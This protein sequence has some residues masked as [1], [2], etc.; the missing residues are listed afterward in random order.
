[1]YKIRLLGSKEQ[2]DWNPTFCYLESLFYP[3]LYLVNRGRLIQGQLPS[4]T[5]IFVLRFQKLCFPRPYN[6]RKPVI[7][8][9]TNGI[10]CGV[11]AIY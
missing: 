2:K 1:M 5:S 10:E 7:D 6:T 11:R 9:T 3:V 8:S 4:C